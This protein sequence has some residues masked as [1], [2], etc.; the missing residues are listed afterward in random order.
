[1]SQVC[2]ETLDVMKNSVQDVLDTLARRWTGEILVA[3]ALGAR[4]FGEY[5]RAVEG[6]SERML[7][8]RLRELEALGLLSRTVVPS[9]PVQVRY[10]PTEHGR[11]LLRAIRPLAAWGLQHE[12]IASFNPPARGR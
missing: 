12:A 3:G 2:L 6:L 10:T 11:E 7:A 1:M 4:R 9:T 5:R 8:L